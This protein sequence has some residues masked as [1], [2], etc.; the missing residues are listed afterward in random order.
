MPWIASRHGVTDI[1]AAAADLEI[2]EAILEGVC[3]C[4]FRAYEAGKVEWGDFDQGV[5]FGQRAELR[6]RRR[7]DSTFHV[8]LVTDGGSPPETWSN[9]QELRAEKK[10]TQVVLWGEPDE[11]AQGWY[12][13]R[14]PIKLPYAQPAKGA[15]NRV[16][17]VVWRYR[18]TEG[19][20]EVSRYVQVRLRK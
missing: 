4:E 13:G 5:L 18:F 3:R 17:I 2:R 14:I 7:D 6:F 9:V 8:V 11:R 19:R 10:E 15:K 16:V 12:E 20:G 1:D